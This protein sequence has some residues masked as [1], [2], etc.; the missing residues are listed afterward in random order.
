[1]FGKEDGEGGYAD[2][3]VSLNLLL[4]NPEENGIEATTMWYS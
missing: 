3:E 1:M 2:A 4:N